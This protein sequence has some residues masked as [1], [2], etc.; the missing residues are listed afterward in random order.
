MHTHSNILPTQEQEH[1]N[2]QFQNSLLHS[3]DCLSLPMKETAL[4]LQIIFSQ[5]EQAGWNWFPA[6]VVML[7]NTNKN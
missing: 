5:I 2:D 4:Q 7:P 3:S 1:T 6:L